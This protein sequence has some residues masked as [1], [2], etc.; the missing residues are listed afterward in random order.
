MQPFIDLIEAGIDA[1]MPAHIL[2]PEVD[3]QPVGFSRYWLKE[4]L[5][6]QLNFHGIIFSD[7]L[8]M[9]GAECAGNYATRAEMALDAGCDI[10]LICNNRAG[11][12]EILDHL[13]EQY[14]LSADKFNRLKSTFSQDLAS[15]HASPVWKKNIKLLSTD[16]N[17]RT[18]YESNR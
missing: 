17:N 16:F 3:A 11:A 8:N 13:P 10:I 9:A 15:I 4:I 5:Q 12:I 6:K 14:T 1:I 2:F 18:I 7:D